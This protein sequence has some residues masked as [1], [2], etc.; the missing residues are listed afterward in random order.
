MDM[1]ILAIRNS[2]N[3]L[4]GFYGRHEDRNPDSGKEFDLD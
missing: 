3:K 2:Q 1:Y 4:I